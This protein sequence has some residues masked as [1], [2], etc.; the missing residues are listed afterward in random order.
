MDG[1][2]PCSAESL[3][4]RGCTIRLMLD[5]NAPF[6]VRAN[7]VGITNRV[8]VLDVDGQ[9]VDL[10]A[11]GSLDQLD[12]AADGSDNTPEVIDDS[13]WSYVPGW[14][15]IGG[16]IEVERQAA[17]S[18]PATNPDSPTEALQ[19]ENLG[20]GLDVS[21]EEFFAWES[22]SLT[23]PPIPCGQDIIEAWYGHPSNPAK[24]VDITEEVRSIANAVADGSP[25]GALE[26]LTLSASNT[27]W[28]DPAMLVWKKLTVKLRGRPAISDN[29]EEIY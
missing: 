6:G 17:P 24:R 22:S 26:G 16:T 4:E 23:L 2:L 5:G 18:S 28:G 25:A 21:A 27:E 10:A 9:L 20:D 7:V 19:E 1:P 13:W 15:L 29:I 14:S 8:S 11:L 3:L 12:V